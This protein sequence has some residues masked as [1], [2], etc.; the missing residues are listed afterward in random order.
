MLEVISQT[1]A[2][3]FGMSSSQ[4]SSRRRSARLAFDDE[5]DARPT[6]K[7]KTTETTTTVPTKQPSTR[8]TVATTKKAKTSKTGYSASARNASV[9]DE[10]S[11]RAI[12]RGSADTVAAY[13]ED[14]DGFHFSR[15]KSKK[16]RATEAKAADTDKPKAAPIAT[17][18]KLSKSTSTRTKRTLPDAPPEEQDGSRHRRSARL[19]GDKLP[20]PA[21]APAQTK[22][23]SKLKA[24]PAA[25]PKPAPIDAPKDVP[26]AKAHETELRPLKT[27]RVEE[28]HA[29]HRADEQIAEPKEPTKIALPFADTPVIQRNK[30]MRKNSAQ[31][32]RRSSAGLRGRR[33]SSLMD[34]GLSNGGLPGIA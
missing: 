4:R 20:A 26:P 12:V 33:A 34:A 25:Q 27:P 9:Q 3:A 16:P 24:K 17:D 14:E 18:E 5:E 11:R 29:D 22:A 8:K 30:E 10:G 6:K 2:H 23:T 13:D 19:S 21:A 28:L 31:G 7:A 32:H 15:A 1:A